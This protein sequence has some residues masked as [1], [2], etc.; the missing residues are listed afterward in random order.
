VV[1][2][3]F[4]LVFWFM[5]VQGSTWYCVCLCK[6]FCK[7]LVGKTHHHRFVWNNKNYYT[8]LKKNL[9][10]LLD[11]YNWGKKSLLMWRWMINFN[12]MTNVLKFVV[13]CDNLNLKET[14]QIT[15]L[16]HVFFKSCQCFIVY[17]ETYKN[18]KYV[19]IKFVHLDL[20]N[21][22]TWL[23]KKGRIKNSGM[24]FILILVFVKLNI[25]IK[26]RSNWI[27]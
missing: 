17:V 20:Q 25:P 13:S 21:C 12:A 1:A 11:H 10:E 26:T 9:V 15:F 22:I 19:C 14:F 5:D 7:W 4:L 27:F 3:D 8:T 24:G 16:G 23:K 2:N 6:F 18:F